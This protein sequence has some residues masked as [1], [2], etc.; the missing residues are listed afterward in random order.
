MPVVYHW[1]IYCITESSWVK[2]YSED[3]NFIP[4]TCPNNAEHEINIHSPSLVE[5]TGEVTV[6]RVLQDEGATQGMFKRK[7]YKRAIPSGQTVDFDHIWKIGISVLEV[8]YFATSANVG[9][10]INLTV[11]PNTPLGSLQ[12]QADQGTSILI[13]SSPILPQMGKGFYIKLA[14]GTILG[15]VLSVDTTNQTI[16]LCSNLNET[17]IIGTL[18]FFEVVMIENEYIHLPQLVKIN[19]A[20]ISS[21][22]LKANTIARLQYINNSDTNKEFVYY[23]NYTY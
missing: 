3:K 14:D 11:S 9:D 17:L 2:T 16:T 6:V 15:T 19:R 12:L 22:P 5:K 10:E 4:S 21:T 1:K 8:G 20:S 18:L 7:G 13:I 23:I